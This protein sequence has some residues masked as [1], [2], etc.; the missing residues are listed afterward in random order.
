MRK[1]PLDVSSRIMMDLRLNLSR[2]HC[3]CCITACSLR[4][5]VAVAP[6]SAATARATSGVA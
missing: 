2:L 6:P 4:V 3:R 5:A 1:F